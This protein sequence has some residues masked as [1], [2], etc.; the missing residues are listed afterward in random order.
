M[1]VMAASLEVKEVMRVL[2]VIKYIH[3][4]GPMIIIQQ[5]EGIGMHA[6]HPTNCS[7]L[8]YT[9]TSKNLHIYT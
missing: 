4:E 1:G 9:D 8:S 2:P 6:L 5:V 7:N 3:L